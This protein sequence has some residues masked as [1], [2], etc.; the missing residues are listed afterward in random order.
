MTQVPTVTIDKLE[1]RIRFHREINTPLYIWGLPGTGKSQVIEQVGRKLAA[2]GGHDFNL[3]SAK[4]V[5]ADPDNTFAVLDL[6]MSGVDAF[7]LKGAMVPDLE[8]RILTFLKLGLLPDEKRHGK[9]GILLLDEYAEAE[10]STIKGSSSLILD[11]KVSDNY[12]LPDG[13]LIVAAS[14]EPGVGGASARKLPA[15]ICNRFGHIRVE[16]SAKIWAEWL[17][18]IGGSPILAAFING[19]PELINSW[20]KDAVA[21]STP[22]S[23]ANVNKVL[24]NVT[25]DR[26][27][28]ESLVAGFIGTGP[29][30]ELEGFITLFNSG[31]IPTWSSIRD[32]PTEAIVPHPGEKHATSI[33]F[34]AVSLISKNV[35]SVDEIPNVIAYL[36]RLPSELQDTALLD[37]KTQQ[38]DLLECR[39]VTAWRSRNPHA[40]I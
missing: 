23:L 28:R 40:V 39:A 31:Q 27:L 37:I 36:E 30:N 33:L 5:P 24:Q 25:E 19:R 11:R 9:Y 10:L 13:W 18:S 4:E 38:P 3:V 12:F 17:R 6:R 34:M 8:N 16:P 21:F 29:A 2:E 35:T 26:D 14:N 20:V 15:H 22:R 1:A 7:D 32:N